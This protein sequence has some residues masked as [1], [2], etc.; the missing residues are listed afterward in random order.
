[1]GVAESVA[2]DYGAGGQHLIRAD[3]GSAS[4][5]VGRDEELK[6][7]RRLVAAVAAGRGG[8]VLVEG[9][10]GIGKTAL[11]S[12]GLDNVRESGCQLFASQA[13]EIVQRFPLQVLLE[14]F[15][16]SPTATDLGRAGIAS[17]L[18]PVGTADTAL[19]PQDAAS[20]AAER[21]LMLVDQLCAGG[22]VVLVVD[23]LQWADDVSL[24]VWGRLNRL[25]SQLPLLLVAACRPVP[26][27]AELDQLRR[28]LIGADAVQLELAALTEREVVDLTGRLLNGVPGPRLRQQSAHAGGNPLYLRELLDALQRDRLVRVGSGAAE[29]VDTVSL[30]PPSLSSAI[31]RRLGFLSEPTVSALRLAAVLGVEFDVAHLSTLT[32]R[33]ATELIAVVRDAVAAG[34]LI[35]SGSRLSFRHAVIR[36][37]LHDEMPA[38][39]RSALHHQAARVLWESGATAEHVAAQLLAAGL[40]PP[41]STND[42]VASWVTSAAPALI[43]RAPQV[44]VDLLERVLDEH[45]VDR[46][47]RPQLAA[48]LTSALFQL[49]RYERID[50]V[51]TLVVAD[52]PDPGIAARVA[53][54]WGYALVR[55]AQY[56]KALDVTAQVL[57]RPDLSAVW[58]ARLLAMRAMIMVNDDRYAEARTVALKAEADG[59]AAGDRLA[60]GYALHALSI[61]ENRYLQDAR[62]ALTTL[63]RALAVLGDDPDAVDLRLLLL[64]NRTSAIDNLGH[65]DEAGRAIGHAVGLAERTGSGP[66]LAALRIRAAEHCYFEGRWDDATAELE[67][68]DDLPLDLARGVWRHGISAL[69][70]AHRDD[71]AALSE[72][73]H[74]ASYPEVTAGDVRLLGHFLLVAQGLA[75]EREQR[76]TQALARLLEAF[77]PDGALSFSEL[78]EDRCLW[79]PDIV[80]IALATDQR[81]T[82]EAAAA[83]CAADAD[84]QRVP[85]ARASA[86]HCQ[87]L[88]DANPTTVQSAANR[89]RAGGYPLYQAQALE[90]AAVL[91]AQGGHTAAARA[92]Q[93][94]AIGLYTTLDAN[95]DLLRAD[96]RLRAHGIRRGVRGIRRG[97]TTGFDALTSTELKIA[98]L[99]AAGH[100]NAG[101]ANVLFLSRATV[102]SHISHILGKLNAHSR[103]DIAREATRRR[104]N[105]LAAHR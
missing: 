21:L 90:N 25:H 70:A 15:A 91:Y 13:D 86:E 101:I 74:K 95:W 34:V 84:R 42:W 49:G 85:K 43:D 102:S 62:A 99:V 6:C 66:R 83:A 59:E 82:A 80:R 87:G 64:A 24:A 23:D 29:L 11:L 36:Q 17:L 20:A 60:I 41:G 26:A 10:P 27:R 35:E 39:L 75:A 38:S 18:W 45:G 78:V 55:L 72:H 1:M 40:S 61:V 76:P 104:E 69:I 5:L 9:E 33:T 56:E 58:T 8:S 105:P 71:R 73:V 79:L 37:A 51:A 12:A 57:A 93:S 77:D 53:W 89:Y 28:S 19:T 67:A 94:E 3:Q 96:T 54:T 50:H 103:V 16:V 30:A 98:E 14:A 47:V 92:A 22:P 100:T 48:H 65:L 88:L 2:R 4:G 97:P 7:L 68:T 31:A 52:M 81:S 46:T 32:G 63:D 44:A